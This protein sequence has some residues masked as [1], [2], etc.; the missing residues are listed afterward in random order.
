MKFFV[1]E[2]A[3]KLFRDLVD[4]KGSPF[5][6]KDLKDV[7]IFSMALAFKLGKRKPLEKKKDI[8]D[9]SVFTESQLLLINSVAV[10]TENKLEV[11][12]DEKKKFEIAEEYANAGVYILHEIVFESKEGVDDAIKILDKKISSLVISNEEKTNSG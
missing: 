5:Y 7:F 6:K 12:L 3:H 4:I 1:D 10:A 11:L 2:K 9:I 8:A